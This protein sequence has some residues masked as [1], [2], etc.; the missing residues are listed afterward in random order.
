[1]YSMKLAKIEVPKASQYFLFNKKRREELITR[2]E[3]KFYNYKYYLTFINLSQ[4]RSA[5]FN[6]AYLIRN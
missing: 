3:N 5:V 1:M 2:E 6:Y 4:I